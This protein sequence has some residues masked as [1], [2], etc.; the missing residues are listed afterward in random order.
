M[1]FFHPV[2]NAPWS[3]HLKKKKNKKKIN[4]LDASV[5]NHFRPISK[6]SF[7]SKVL[8]KVVS[9]QLI[10]FLDNNELF[11]IRLSLPAQF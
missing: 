4:T 2:L 6:L 7:L 3:I 1:A 10:A 11:E 5:L 9:T 8:E